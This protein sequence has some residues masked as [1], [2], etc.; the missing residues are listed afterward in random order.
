MRFRQPAVFSR[1]APYGP[2][3]LRIAMGIVFIAHGMQKIDNGMA[4][5]AGFFGSLNIP[6]PEVMAWVITALEVGG[7]VLLLL[8]L[9]TRIVALLFAIQMVFTIAL[10]RAEL[11]LV[12]QQGTGAEIDLMLLAAGLALAFTGPGAAAVDRMIGLE[13]KESPIHA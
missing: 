3:V 1:L 8:G 12:A 4:G 10:V 11:G 5:V 9:G 6:M 2:T 13:P 7:G